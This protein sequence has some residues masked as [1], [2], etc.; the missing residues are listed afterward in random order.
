[1]Q[2]FEQNR[3]NSLESQHRKN[4]Y[5]NKYFSIKSRQ[6]NLWGKEKKS[7]QAIHTKTQ[8]T[9]ERLF[10]VDHQI[11]YVSR[12]PYPSHCAITREGS[13]NCLSRSNKARHYRPQTYRRSQKLLF[14]TRE[15][16][17]KIMPSQATK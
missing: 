9:I 16:K 12:F 17:R 5:T 2:Y 10:K 7:N 13:K 3:R 11:I 8:A 15:W 6:H 4:R 1:M 14:I